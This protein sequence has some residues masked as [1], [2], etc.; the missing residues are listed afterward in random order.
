VGQDTCA[1]G[2]VTCGGETPGLCFC[3]VT[4]GKASFCA[5]TGISGT[6]T[7]DE[8]CVPTKGEGAACVVCGGVGQCAA[9]CSDPA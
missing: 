8:E 7:Q 3:L 5:Q 1:T 6:C 9:R 2:P 4:T